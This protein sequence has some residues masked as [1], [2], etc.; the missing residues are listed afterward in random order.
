MMSPMAVMKPETTG[1]GIYR[2]YFP[3]FKKPNAT[4]IRPAKINTASIMGSAFSTLPSL[5]AI[6]VPM[7]TILT[8]VIGAVGPEIC[9]FVS[10]NRAAK[11]L[12]NIAP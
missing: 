5:D 8:A 1:Y 7:M 3:S 6:S 10:P 9:V 4:C 12:R 2:M 11:K